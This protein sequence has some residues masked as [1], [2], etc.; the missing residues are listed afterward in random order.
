MFSNEQKI[1]KLFLYWLV[2]SLILVFLI[3]I[4]GGLTRLTNSG[5]S[6]TE[7]ELFRGILPPLNNSEWIFYFDQYKQIPQYKLLNFNMSLEEF[8]VI[9]YWEYYHRIL[10]RFIG[11]FF[12]IATFSL[13]SQIYFNR[14]NS[15]SVFGKNFNFLQAYF[16]F[17]VYVLGSDIFFFG[18]GMSKSPELKITDTVMNFISPLTF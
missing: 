5:L 9:F 2:T 8:K 13:N 7:W 17:S 11:I 6:I 4:V 18:I 10:A 1:K 12:L 15:L 3:I 16:G 14:F